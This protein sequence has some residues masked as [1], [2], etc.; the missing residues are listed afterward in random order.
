MPAFFC[1]L[2]TKIIICDIIMITKYGGAKWKNNFWMKK[3]T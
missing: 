3:Q 1:L 2:F